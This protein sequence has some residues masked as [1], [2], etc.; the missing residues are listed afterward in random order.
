MCALACSN[1]WTVSSIL[2]SPLPLYL[3]ADSAGNAAKT[4]TRFVT[5]I[6]DGGVCTINGPEVR[7]EFTIAFPEVSEAQLL[8]DFAF[9]TEF[10]TA[11]QYEFIAFR[12]LSVMMTATSIIIAVDAVIILDTTNDLETRA[13][14]VAILAG[15]HWP[16]LLEFLR[17]KSSSRCPSM[18]SGQP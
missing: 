8:G 6:A 11:Y 3:E 18:E 17:N 12:A 2:N 15:P 16:H 9:S 4:L 10:L 1:H 14:L 13:L 7:V 5:V